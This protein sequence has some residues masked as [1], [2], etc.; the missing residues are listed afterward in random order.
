MDWSV[1]VNRRSV[2]AIRS[3]LFTPATKADRFGRAAEAGADALIVD[4]EDGVGPSQ[5]RQARSAALQYLE[6]LPAGGPPC[7]LRI[8]SV[9]TRAG[10]DDLQSFLNSTGKPDFLIL[11]KCESVG[12][13]EFLAALL[14]EA[15][16]TAEILIQIET[17]KGVAALEAIARS[18]HRPGAFIFGAADMAAD[19]GAQPQWESLL[20][21]RS[22]IVHAAALGGIA[23]VD[24][25]FFDFGDRDGLLHE[26]ALAARLGFHSKCA[27]HPAQVSII[28]EVFTP[29]GEEI[30]KAQEILDA[31]R[32]GAGSVSGQ[33]V[34]EATARSARLVLQRVRAAEGDL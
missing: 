29:S 1:N 17:A 19:L 6:G 30:R 22:R 15:G 14:T 2:Q 24:S 33:M 10:L 31:T 32:H 4:L 27:I 26:A 9:R 34:D 16:K 28:N 7:A 23:I 5:K 12:E 18:E 20:W 11:P 21:V 3:W 25:P 8:N 13:I